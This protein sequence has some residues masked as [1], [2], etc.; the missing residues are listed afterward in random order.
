M[1]QTSIV[2]GGAGDDIIRSF[3]SLS[4]VIIGHLATIVLSSTDDASRNYFVE[5]I[6]PP[7]PMPMENAPSDG[8]SDSILVQVS[9]A[10]LTNRDAEVIII[11]ASGN[12]TITCDGPLSAIICSDQCQGNP[13]TSVCFESHSLSKVSC[14]Y[15][16]PM[17]RCLSHNKYRRNFDSITYRPWNGFH[18]LQWTPQW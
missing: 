9:P 14:C 4:S 3:D 16:E 13:S 12:D 15:S 8:Y 10:N 17:E 1:N 7:L 6:S 5:T 18:H 11:T 2:L